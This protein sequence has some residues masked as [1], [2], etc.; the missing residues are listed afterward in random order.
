MPYELAWAVVL[1]PLGAAG[2]SY[3]TELPRRA[4][5]IN[6]AGIFVSFVLATVI[7]FYR[8][9]HITQNPYQS[10][11]TFFSYA[12]GS[13]PAGGFINAFQPQVGVLIDGLSA[14]V[15]AVV[16]LVSLLVQVYSLAYMRN[17]AGMRR[18]FVVLNI[19]T[20]SM[21]G[22][23]ASPNLFNAYV[24]WEG[25][26]VCSFL[27]IGHW[28][29]RPAAA[30]AA[31]KAFLVTRIGDIS[32]LLALVFTFTK[33]ASA[34]AALP[35]PSD[36]SVNSANNEPFNFQTMGVL[37][38]HVAAGT[39]PGAGT[40]TL[41]VLAILVLVAALAKSAQF[42]FH[43]WLPD[44]MEGPIPVSA[45]IHAATMV[46]AGVYLVAR[47]YP[48]FLLAPHMLTA[49]ALVG[50][51]TAVLGALV[52]LAQD[53]IK[54]I[55]AWST[56]SHLGLMFVG[57]GVGAYG[58]AMFHLFTHAWFKAL[59]F[60]AA[61]NVIAAYGTQNIRE[62]GGVWTRMRVTAV[63]ML[64]GC[65]SA[66][67]VILF[68]GFWSKDSI[69][70]GVLR[71]ELPNGGHLSRLA[72][73]LLVVAVCVTTLA[74]AIYPFRMYFVAFL[75]APARRRGFQPDRIREPNTLM[76]APVAILGVLATV[77][78]YVGIEG[79]RW[80]L[81]K[82]VTAGPD[83]AGFPWA[84][85]VLGGGLALAGVAVAYGIWVARVPALVALPRRLAGVRPLFAS[86]LR[87]DATYASVT[88]RAVALVAPLFPR[89]DAEITDAIAEGAE[90]GVVDLGQEVRRLQ[91]GRI[92]TYGL[93]AF[94]GVLLI[95]AGVTLAA[96][97]H[98]PGVGGAR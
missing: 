85:T 64:A 41:E 90:A 12:P 37:W 22:F 54:R 55:I 24:M 56:I 93:G 98:L 91:T 35:A 72:Q 18:F 96:T 23:V 53:D 39:V 38:Q 74:G 89:V 94:V 8:V 80:N 79:F 36:A 70:G 1:L 34:A 61:G 44:A 42:P 48:L 86:G 9:A 25:I 73:V 15:L 57:L 32:L 29:H 11:I 92:Q 88:S 30:A 6:V 26:G 47:M 60:L 81:E 21:L 46:A 77:A 20:F 84:A 71:N 19:F 58:A 67:G 16:A 4:V 45:L 2:L 43:V 65:C 66:A 5:L 87:I 49:I 13:T 95:A 68:A 51:L 97:G 40:R 14:V 82:A 28:W 69:I 75:G 7:L 17:D 52:A 63:C 62:M 3:I 33:L 78:G 31:K 10:Y 50:A 83:T 59:M 76:L 27:L